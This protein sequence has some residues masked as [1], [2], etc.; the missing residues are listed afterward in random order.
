[1]RIGQLIYCDVNGG[2]HQI[3]VGFG[4]ITEYG[5]THEVVLFNPRGPEE[6]F[7]VKKTFCRPVKM[8]EII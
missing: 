4:T 3:I 5:E 2:L 8:E 1:M 7:W 6:R